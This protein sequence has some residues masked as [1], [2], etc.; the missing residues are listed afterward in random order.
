MRCT[1]VGGPL[2]HLQPR[3]IQLRKARLRLYWQCNRDQ[4]HQLRLGPRTDLK[5]ALAGGEMVT[6]KAIKRKG[7]HFW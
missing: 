6:I 7:P 1:C 4:L 2:Q 5:G 3:H